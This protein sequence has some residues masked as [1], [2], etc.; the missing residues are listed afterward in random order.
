MA[1]CLAVGAKGGGDGG[2]VGEDSI[3]TAEGTQTW[4]K[5]IS[6]MLE[7]L[8]SWWAR[9]KGAP[10]RIC[11][12]GEWVRGRGWVRVCVFL[13]RGREGGNRQ[14]WSTGRAEG[15]RTRQEVRAEASQ[16]PN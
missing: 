6:K 7:I 12:P 15:C 13:G 11:E 8:S 9:E 2:G 14:A 5:G 3:S 1:D 4:E 10:L 16:G